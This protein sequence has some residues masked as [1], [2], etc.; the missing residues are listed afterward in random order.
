MREKKENNKNL[1]NLVYL[2]EIKKL[3]LSKTLFEKIS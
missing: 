2:S 3:N 1:G